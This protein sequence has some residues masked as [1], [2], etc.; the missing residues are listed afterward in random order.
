MTDFDFKPKLSQDS[1][2]IGMQFRPSYQQSRNLS[3]SELASDDDLESGL[4]LVAESSKKI[5][6]MQLQFST[7]KRDDKER[8]KVK[9]PVR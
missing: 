4:K 9:L 8:K 3:G 7:E 1:K 6:A 2:P 5:P